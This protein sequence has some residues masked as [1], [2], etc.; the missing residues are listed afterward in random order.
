MRRRHR[1]KQTS[2]LESLKHKLETE[3]RLTG[4]ELRFGPSSG[5]KMSEV[6]SEFIEPWIEVADTRAAY[7]RLIGTA[8]LAW[9]AA[10]LP[11]NERQKMLDAA[12]KTIGATADRQTLKDFQVIMADFIRRKER[13]FADN[14]RFI[15]G[16]EIK[17][18]RDGYH[19]S[20]AS[21][22]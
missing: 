3:M 20:V 4:Q 1:Q 17:E 14:K 16:Y 10:L 15:V 11:K 7:D 6:L 21:T 22:Q 18:V 8:I 13:H 19:L 12:A 5:E 2:S 9:N